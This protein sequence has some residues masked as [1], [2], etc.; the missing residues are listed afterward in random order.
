MKKGGSASN[1]GSSTPRCQ[2][3]DHVVAESVRDGLDRVAGEEMARLE[4]LRVEAERKA[5][6]LAAKKA[7]EDRKVDAEE[8]RIKRLVQ[9]MTYRKEEPLVVEGWWFVI[10]VVCCISTLLYRVPDMWIEWLCMFLCIAMIEIFF[11][12]LNGEVSPFYHLICAFLF[13]QF[14]TMKVDVVVGKMS[15][16]EIDQRTDRLAVGTMKHMNPLI[17]EL[18]ITRGYGPF[19]FGTHT[20]YVSHEVIAQLSDAE[21]VIGHSDDEVRRMMESKAKFLYSI[22]I[23]RFAMYENMNIYKNSIQVAFDLYR[24]AEI[25]A[26]RAWGLSRRLL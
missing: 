16:V 21:I 17:T 1:S 26:E 12:Y 4:H 10:L 19:T 5:D 3:N 22:N 20:M 11:R 8:Q 14:P 15:R 13:R 25:A 6:E 24:N 18:F 9:R 23:D 7:E 2:K